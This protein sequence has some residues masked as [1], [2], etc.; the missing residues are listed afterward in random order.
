MKYRRYNLEGDDN[1][2]TKVD[3]VKIFRFPEDFEKYDFDFFIHWHFPYEIIY[4][5]RGSLTI[6]KDGED[7]VVN[8]NEIHFLNS[9]EVHFYANTQADYDNNLRFI[10]MNI[11]LK[12]VEPY[13]DNPANHP[14][15][16]IEDETARKNI[17]QVMKLLYDIE[18]YD[19]PYEDLK[20]K[21]ILNY[22][23]YQLTSFCYNPDYKYSK[24]SDSSDYDCAKNAIVYMENNYKKN[25]TL[26]DISNYI[27]M[28]PSHFSNYFKEKT[29]TP[30]LKFL[31]R[32][33]LDKAISDMRE[34]NT[35][36]KDAALN[37]G[38]PNVNSLIS[39]CKEVYDKTPHEMKMIAT[40]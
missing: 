25:I 20:I 12:M 3:G 5:E 39:A 2:V 21:A 30:F 28:T 8:A 40:K 16:F 38:F 4:V 18:D 10:L 23:L 13:F 35:S 6:R 11:P 34:N 9:E 24:G 33:R 22:I 15:F 27:G 36:V 32:I 17:T 1:C 14:T 31:R 37:S 7:V 26:T 29:G 19:A